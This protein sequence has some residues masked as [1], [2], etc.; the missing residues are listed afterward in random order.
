MTSPV[1]VDQ[2]QVLHAWMDSVYK[3][4]PTVLHSE[5]FHENNFLVT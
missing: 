1:K 3:S 2:K 4:F 5:S